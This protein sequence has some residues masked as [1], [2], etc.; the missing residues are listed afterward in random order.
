M[1]FYYY[2]EV[3]YM[4]NL[5]KI[6]HKI[7]YKIAKMCAFCLYVCGNVFFFYSIFCVIYIC[8]FCTKAKGKSSKSFNTYHIII[9]LMLL[10]KCIHMYPGHIIYHIYCF[11]AQTVIP[12]CHWY[13]NWPNSTSKQN[14]QLQYTY[15]SFMHG[16]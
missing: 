1:E 2:I 11:L 13:I 3:I 14:V 6:R 9:N 8:N 4:I 16:V 10:V 12:L 5:R 15:L 7:P